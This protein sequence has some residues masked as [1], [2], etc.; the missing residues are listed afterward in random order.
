MK[1]KITV[2]FTFDDTWDFYENIIPDQII[3]AALGR[4]LS[5]VSYEVLKTEKIKS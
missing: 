2:V 4:L 3:E 5:G 1:K